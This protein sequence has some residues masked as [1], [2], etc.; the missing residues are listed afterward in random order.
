MARNNAVYAAKNEGV[1][2]IKIFMNRRRG[3]L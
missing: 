3:R 1:E 2:K